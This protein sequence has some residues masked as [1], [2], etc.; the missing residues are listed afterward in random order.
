[1]Q[2]PWRKPLKKATFW[3]LYAVSGFLE[4]RHLLQR[5][6]GEKK[7]KKEGK[8]LPKSHRCQQPAHFPSERDFE[9]IC[10][11][12]PSARGGIMPT[13]LH[14]ALLLV[15][16]WDKNCSR[17]GGR[18]M[19]YGSHWRFLVV[20]WNYVGLESVVLNQKCDA[21]QAAAATPSL[22]GCVDGEGWQGHWGKD[23]DIPFLALKVASKLMF[24]H[25]WQNLSVTHSRLFSYGVLIATCK[26][27][28]SPVCLLARG[29]YCKKYSNLLTF[30]QAELNVLEDSS[31]KWTKV[32]SLPKTKKSS[33]MQHVCHDLELCLPF[34]ILKATRR[35]MLIQQRFMLC[36][37]CVNLFWC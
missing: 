31:V 7:G 24:R 22:Q 30:T 4:L 33:R 37:S 19:F 13:T 2:H 26:T 8:E 6:R 35:F 5:G 32:T 9:D 3:S 21:D 29:T 23:T 12:P 36:L 11:H 17:G 16:V 18:Q 28:V 20:C 14:T 27:G 10:A 1:M 34:R 25:C 15:M